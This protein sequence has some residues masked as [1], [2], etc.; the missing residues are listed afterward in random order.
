M[1]QKKHLLITV[2]LN[3]YLCYSPQLKNNEHSFES[4]FKALFDEKIGIERNQDLNLGGLDM[5][6][7]S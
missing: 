6:P 1:T 7:E 3:F 4:N 5:E 2:V